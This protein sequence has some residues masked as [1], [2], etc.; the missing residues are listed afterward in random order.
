M[1][2]WQELATKRDPLLPA[3]EVRRE[4][5]DVSEV[6]LWRWEKWGV[7]PPAVRIRSRKYWRK[8]VVEALKSQAA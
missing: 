3:I 1:E 7:L 6:T 4:L 5:G 2:N 8:S